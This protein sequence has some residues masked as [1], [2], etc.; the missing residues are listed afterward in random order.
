MDNLHAHTLAV[1]HKQR[2]KG[3]PSVSRAPQRGWDIP[4]DGHA[5]CTWDGMPGSVTKLVL[6]RLP[7]MA[8]AA[9]AP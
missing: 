4:D 6:G 7:R 9:I 2:G 3:E 8:A 5:E 1:N